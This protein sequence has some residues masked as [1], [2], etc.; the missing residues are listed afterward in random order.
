[1]DYLTSDTI[2]YYINRKNAKCPIH[3]AGI[4]GGL[5]KYGVYVKCDYGHFMKPDEI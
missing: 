2:N 5:G 1:M 3:K 4:C